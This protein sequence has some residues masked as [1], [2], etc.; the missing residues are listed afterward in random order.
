MK[1]TVITL[2]LFLFI[3]S[4]EKI[5]DNAIVAVDFNSK[6]QT[7]KYKEVRPSVGVS[8]SDFQVCLSNLD[9]NKNLTNLEWKDIELKGPYILDLLDYKKTLKSNIGFIKMKKGIYKSIGMYFFFN[10]S[11]PLQKS[12]YLS[13]TI[14]DVP[15]EFWHNTTEKFK[16]INNSGVLID[17]QPKD[18]VISFDIDKFL[19]SV[20]NINL[21]INL[22][23]NND[24]LIKI[25]PDDD[26]GNSYIADLIKENII[27][28][29][30][31]SN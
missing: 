3:L 18:I 6:I 26:D 9:F 1:K 31:F 27:S 5:D 4:C 2:F 7:L 15:F 17:C 11:N 19:N 10:E 16:I 28:S 23:N 30:T 25:N 13:G 24:G 14:D 29:L 21:N 22:D 8:I 20:N 12:I